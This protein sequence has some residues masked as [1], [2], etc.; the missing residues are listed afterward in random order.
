MQIFFLENKYFF[1]YFF[2]WFSSVLSI[3]A[4]YLP[5]DVYYNKPW[6]ITYL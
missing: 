2:I 4:Q 1:I 6:S 5:V 3:N